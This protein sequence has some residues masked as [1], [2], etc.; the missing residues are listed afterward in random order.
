MGSLRGCL[1]CEAVR[2][3]G[4]V[5]LSREEVSTQ[6]LM[7]VTRPPAL[8]PE[9]RL[10]VSLTRPGG[11]G[12]HGACGWLPVCRCRGPG[13]RVRA[14]GVRTG[15][16][17]SSCRGGPGSAGVIEGRT[18][19][20]AQ[21]QASLEERREVGDLGQAWVR[22]A[23]GSQLSAW[24]CGRL[25]CWVVMGVRGVCAG[26]QQGRLRTEPLSLR[27]EEVAEVRGA[28]QGGGRHVHEKE[29]RCGDAV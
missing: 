13:C 28:R 8:G 6:L 2:G 1:L 20:R 4:A 15:V 29:V 21:S 9:E 25:A 24:S 7:A 23:V 17:A 12:G 14:L 3:T 10:G 27:L 11:G 18:E 19:S 26:G 5:P 22:G 16:G